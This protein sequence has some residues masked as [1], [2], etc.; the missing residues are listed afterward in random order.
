MELNINNQLFIVCGATSGFGLGITRL[1]VSEKA[2]VIAIAR[3]KEKLDELAA[4]FHGKIEVFEGDITR[5]STIDKLAKQAGSRKIHGILINAGGPPAMSFNETRLEDWDN[6]YH[7]LLRWKVEITKSFIP[8]MV[9]QGYGRFVFIESAAIKHYME[10][11]VLS[12]SM[13]LSVAG[14]VKTLSQELPDKGITFNIL[15]PGYHDTP[16]LDRLIRKK[17]EMKD[18]SY[19]LAKQS[20]EDNIPLK[21][22]GSTGDF[23]SLAVWLLSPL[24]GYVTGQ[25]FAVDGGI[26]KSVL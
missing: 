13:R 12:T 11:L 9:R 19:E 8:G 26:I 24:S 5:S 25:I 18:T 10:N 6:A 3:R 2:K 23:A 14:F 21:K 15:A 16:A 7:Q 1:L 22:T 17:A 20:I 4:E